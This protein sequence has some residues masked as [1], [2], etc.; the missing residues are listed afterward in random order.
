M[1]SNYKN[2][3]LHGHWGQYKLGKVIKTANYVDGLMDGM[4]RE[5][6]QK[7]ASPKLEAMY[8]MGKQDGPMKYYNDKGEVVLEY[9]F[10]NGKQIGK[11][12]VTKH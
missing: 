3:K 8:K 12:K 7:D 5:L 10:K 11:A 1:Q 6:N 2:N 4:Y 9:N